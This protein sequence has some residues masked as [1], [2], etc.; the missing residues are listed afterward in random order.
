MVSLPRSVFIRALVPITWRTSAR[1]MG[2]RLRFFSV[3]EADS[4][5]QLLYALDAVDDPS[6]GALVLQHAL[7]EVHHACEFE[8]VAMAYRSAPPPR[9]LPRRRPIFERER[10]PEAWPEFFAHAH[11]GENDVFQQFDAYTKGVGD[12]PARSVFTEA[13][14]DERGH[15]GLTYKLLLIYSGTP[16]K[17]NAFV[18][19]AR[20]ARAWETWLRLSRR[21]GSIPARLFLR[22]MSS[23]RPQQQLHLLLVL[24]DPRRPPAR[25]RGAAER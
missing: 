23:K 6:T 24:A 16:D 19:R 21:L 8:R 22:R 3:M 17:A 25:P 13:K 5:W 4:A 11:V 10:G 9:P 15:A 1:R 14:K 7:E 20:R 12:C 2:S 18:R